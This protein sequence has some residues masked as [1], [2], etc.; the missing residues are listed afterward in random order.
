M[1]YQTWDL[2]H[3]LGE[4]YNSK[5]SSCSGQSEHIGGQS[6][7]GKNSADR[8]VSEGLCDSQTVSD[9]RSSFSRPVCIRNESQDCSL[10][11]IDSQS[12]GLS[13]RRIINCMENMEAY[14]FPSICLIPEVIQHMKNFKCQMI[15]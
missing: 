9:L 4:Q 12:V 11:H 8:M 6:E 5:S 10:L 15:T 7:Q 14:A 3:L 13:D 1:C 2:W